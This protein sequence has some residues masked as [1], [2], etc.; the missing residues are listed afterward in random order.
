M[1]L[2]FDPLILLRVITK[3][4]KPFVLVP[5]EEI[6]ISIHIVKLTLLIC[7]AVKAMV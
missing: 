6:M 5:P 2:E 1:A 4:L 7:N 3:S